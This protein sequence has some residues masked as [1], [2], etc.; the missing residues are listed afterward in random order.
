[1][2][3]NPDKTPPA[4][5]VEERAYAFLLAKNEPP[6]PVMALMAEYMS[7]FAQAEIERQTP[8]IIERFA[9][10]VMKEYWELAAVSSLPD[11]MVFQDAMQAVKNR[12]TAQAVSEGDE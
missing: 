2:T 10:D 3:N 9:V 6:G 1:M 12:L 11:R 5:S 8:A 7:D 4:E